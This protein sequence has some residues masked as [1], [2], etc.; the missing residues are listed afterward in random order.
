LA[1]RAG[2]GLPSVNLENVTIITEVIHA[3]LEAQI[4]IIIVRTRPTDMIILIILSDIGHDHHHHLMITVGLWDG[5]FLPL[6]CPG[7]VPTLHHLPLVQKMMIQRTTVTRSKMQ[8]SRCTVSLKG[9]LLVS[10]RKGFRPQRLLTLLKS[11][12][13]ARRNKSDEGRGCSAPI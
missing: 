11:K 13:T 10:K 2:Y 12:S 8:R 3:T 1:F 6:L 4:I 9:F 5:T 7:W